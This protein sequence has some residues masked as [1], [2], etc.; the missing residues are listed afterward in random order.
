MEKYPNIPPMADSKDSSHF[1]IETLETDCY[2]SIEFVGPGARLCQVQPKFVKIT[3][4]TNCNHLLSLLGNEWS[5]RKPQLLISVTGGAHNFKLTSRLQDI[6]RDGVIEAAV[7]TGAW[8]ITGGTN[9]GVMKYIGEAVKDFKT[10]CRIHDVVAIGI[11]TWG[12]LDQRSLLEDVNYSNRESFISTIRQG[13]PNEVLLD[14]NHTHFI[15]VDDGSEGKYG[16][17]V[18]LRA[19]LEE[20][21]STQWSLRTQQNDVTKI[22]LV[23]IALEGG[24]NTIQTVYEAVQKDTPVIIVA[25]TGRASDAMALAFQR[26][27]PSTEG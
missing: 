24:P 5:L 12:I 18:Q 2:G 15:L 8:I 19:K 27:E 21:I 26:A 4:E 23:C 11:A 7:N 20:T 16:V 9:V 3:P 1:F 14:P 6:F 22:P 25:D 17:E 10:D 13:E